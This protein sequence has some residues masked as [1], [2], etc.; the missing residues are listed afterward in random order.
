MIYRTRLLKC[1]VVCCTIAFFAIAQSAYA[2]NATWKNTGGTDWNTGGNWTGGTGTGGIPGSA[3]VATFGGAEVSNPNLSADDIILGLNFQST[4]TGYTL[5]NTNGAKLTLTA[6]GTGATSSAINLSNTTLTNTISATLIFGA[7]SGTQTVSQAGGGTLILSGTLSNTNP[8]TL[9]LTGGGIIR[10][11]ADN[12]AGLS[13]PITL[14]GT[15]T[16]LQVGNDKALG[17]GAITISSSDTIQSDT[18][19]SR[20]LANNVILANGSSATTFGTSTTGALT[21]GSLTLNTSTKNV[22]VENSTTTFSSLG[23]DGSPHQLN[24]SGAGALLIT[25]NASQGA[26]VISAGILGVGGSYTSTGNITLGGGQIGLNGTFTRGLGTS[27]SQ[28]QFTDSGGFAAYGTNATWGNAANNLSVNIGNGGATLTWGDPNFLA[29]GKTLILGSTVSN[30]TVTLVNGLNFGASNQT[31]QV[32]RG[33]TA[34]TGGV[35]AKISGVIGSSGGGLIKTGGGTLQLTAN[36]TYTGATTINTNGGIL[37]IN[38]TNSTSS[39]R[40]SGTSGVTVNSGGTLLLS[41]SSSFT[42]RINNAAGVTLDGTGKFNTGGLS[43]G[44][45]PVPS[46][47][48]NGVVGMGALTLQNTA[49]GSRAV[50]DFTSGNSSALVF[51]SLSGASG[52]FVN[53]LNW[54]GVANM[55]SGAPTNDRLLFA[56]DPSLTT[57][58]LANWTFF[59]DSGTAFATGATVIPFG[60][61]FEI[62]PVPEPS[63]WIGGALALLAVGWTQRKRFAKRLRVTS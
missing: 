5:S 53:I 57:T 31:I 29:S 54:T 41:G 36:N 42:D 43:E 17:S 28:V 25:G 18:S 27:S 63:T 56:V 24:K 20:N 1:A 34:P 7:A 19:A 12:S 60:N 9:S 23:N 45:A 16:T 40:I 62:V 10:I 48:T 35:D 22:D 4:A 33:A 2:A 58:D 52:A 11:T 44:T 49:T 61:E 39:G 26:S 59:N 50:I 6:T 15:G 8:I 13:T 47:P 32:D 21:F 46:T 38:N 14:G 3:D 55:D 30:G 37:D 51:N